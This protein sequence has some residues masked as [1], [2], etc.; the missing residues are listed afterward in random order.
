M[1]E[2]IQIGN[3]SL[4][5]GVTSKEKTTVNVNVSNLYS[6]D[7]T[8]FQMRFTMYVDGPQF[9]AQWQSHGLQS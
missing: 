9:K 5:V 8:T 1:A 3:S 2:K 6:A 4:C 7:Y